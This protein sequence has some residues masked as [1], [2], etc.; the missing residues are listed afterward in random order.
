MRDL[1]VIL[2][3]WWALEQVQAPWISLEHILIFILVFVISYGLAY[4]RRANSR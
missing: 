1:L 3:G 4:E 2:G